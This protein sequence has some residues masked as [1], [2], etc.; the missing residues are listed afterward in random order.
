[1]TPD[2]KLLCQQLADAWNSHDIDRI[3]A[4]YSEDFVLVSP[5][6]KERMGVPDGTLRGKAEVRKWWEPGLKK[7]TDLRMEYIDVLQ[8]VDSFIFVQHLS[9]MDSDSASHFWL[10]EDGLIKREEFFY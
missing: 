5:M 8:G 2:V 3:L 4:H 9:L 10:D 7:F 1:M 6:V